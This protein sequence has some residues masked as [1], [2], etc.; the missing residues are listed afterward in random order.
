MLG[1]MACR[2]Y[3]V[4]GMGF[5]EIVAGRLF[6]KVEVGRFS[7]SSKR[8]CG[9]GICREDNYYVI[10]FLVS[11]SIKKMVAYN[12]KCCLEIIEQGIRKLI[13]GIKY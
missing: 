5:V 2:R 8:V 7:L 10:K 4:E 9:N 13:F 3:A 1:S 11:P 6:T 12:T